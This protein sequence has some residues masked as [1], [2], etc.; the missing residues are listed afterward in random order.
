MFAGS[1][2]QLVV[3][4]MASYLFCTPSALHKKIADIP[5]L[6]MEPAELVNV[7]LRL[8]QQAKLAW[9]N[10]ITVSFNDWKLVDCMGL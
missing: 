8:T 9:N 2:G 6:G 3:L 5:H 1:R 7:G 4:W 10:K